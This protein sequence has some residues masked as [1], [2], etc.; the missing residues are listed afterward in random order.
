MPCFKFGRINITSKDFYKQN[1]VT[2][3]FTIDVN[4]VMVSDKNASIN[5]KD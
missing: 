2:S 1:Q 3:I 5:G 4:K